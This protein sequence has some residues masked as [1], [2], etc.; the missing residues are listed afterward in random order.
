MNWFHMKNGIFC[1]TWRNFSCFL[2]TNVTGSL[3]A[4]PPRLCLFSSF[5]S[6]AAQSGILPSSLSCSCLVKQQKISPGFFLPS[7]DRIVPRQPSSPPP[8][9]DLSPFKACSLS[10]R[11]GEGVILLFGSVSGK[12]QRCV[13]VCLTPPPWFLHVTPKPEGKKLCVRTDRGAWEL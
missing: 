5:L 1:W 10:W 3:R 7:G 4:F 13:V 6:S 9:W 8:G 11:R 2:A 12:G